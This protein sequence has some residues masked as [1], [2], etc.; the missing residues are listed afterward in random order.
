MILLFYLLVF[1]KS[2]TRGSSSKLCASWMFGR[3]DL[4]L[5]LNS[6]KVIEAPKKK[7]KRRCVEFNPVSVITRETVTVRHRERERERR[8]RYVSLRPHTLVRLG[9]FAT[10]CSDKDS[11]IV[12]KAS[13]VTRSSDTH[14][15]NICIHLRNEDF[16]KEKREKRKEK[17]KETSTKAR[18]HTHTKN[19]TSMNASIVP[20]LWN[21]WFTIS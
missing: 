11:L 17:K 3:S 8:G 14:R 7:K 5:N 10:C 20:R 18:T 4:I 13:E 21:F 12:W 1:Y 19:P 16:N 15:I 9:V 2:K 6:E